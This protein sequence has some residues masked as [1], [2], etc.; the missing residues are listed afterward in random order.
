MVCNAP[1][2]VPVRTGKANGALSRW[3]AVVAPGLCGEHRRR[4]QQWR[5]LG[6]FLLLVSL[7]CLIAG[8]TEMIQAGS[9]VLLFAGIFIKTNLVPSISAVRVDDETIELKGFREAFLASLPTEPP[10][11]TETAI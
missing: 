8:P 3:K 1:A 9:A 10:P 4:R 5:W 7:P 11:S 2:E 6:W